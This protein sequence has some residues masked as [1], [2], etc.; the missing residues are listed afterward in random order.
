MSSSI[1]KFWFG[2]SSLFKGVD[3]LVKHPQLRVYFLL[4]LILYIVLFVTGVV[5]AFSAV[6]ALI[7]ALLPTLVGFWWNALYYII[8]A[9][10]V[11]SIVFGS[12]LVILL[13]ASSLA[14]PLFSVLAEKTMLQLG[15]SKLEHRGIAHFLHMLIV[16]LV[17]SV[18]FVLLSLVLFLFSFI[19]G[20]NVI[21]AFMGFLILAMDCC[22][23]SLEVTGMGLN[24]RMQFLFAHWRELSGFACALGLS[25]LLPLWN[26]L[27]LPIAVVGGAHLVG[28][29]TKANQ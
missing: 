27:F 7:S 29:L 23:Y 12:A 13:L 4:P 2:F 5:F 21:A 25:L 14:A 20:L 24:R 18:V 22:D 9:L 26:I 15:Y 16:G 10:L 11:T 17:K 6:P 1:Q 8:V 3:I 28:H 19:P